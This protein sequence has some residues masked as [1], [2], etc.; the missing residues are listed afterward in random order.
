MS[1]AALPKHP[2]WAPRDQP[3]CGQ[4]E[5]PAGPGGPHAGG[6]QQQLQRNLRLHAHPQSA[7]DHRQQAGRLTL[8]G[9]HKTTL[10][11]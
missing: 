9:Q 11:C 6:Q 7:H 2:K 8:Q 1:L 4:P 5:L 10:Q 3:L